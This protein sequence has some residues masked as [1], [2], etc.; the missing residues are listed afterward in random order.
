MGP[1]STLYQGDR[2]AALDTGDALNVYARHGS[3]KWIADLA[4]A[5]IGAIGFGLWAWSVPYRTARRRARL[6]GFLTSHM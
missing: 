6:N 3:R 4:C 2:L 1:H 5:V